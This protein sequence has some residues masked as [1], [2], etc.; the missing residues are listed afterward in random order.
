MS[1]NQ[2]KVVATGSNNIAPID[3]DVIAQTIKKIYVKC[4]PPQ[5]KE[6]QKVFGVITTI[7]PGF[8]L[9][10]CCFYGCDKPDCHGVWLSGLLMDITAC[11]IYGWVV[12]CIVGWKMCGC[13]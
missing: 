3:G 5:Y 12:A 7:W 8:G 6:F 13:C 11:C 2:A 4:E 10:F 1:G 9:Y